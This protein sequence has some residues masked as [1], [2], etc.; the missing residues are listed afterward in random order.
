METKTYPAACTSAYC[1]RTTCPVD[2]PNLET[3]RK[4]KAWRERVAA[5]QPDST[6]SPSVW[7]ATKREA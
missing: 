6:W 7:V 1:G 4:F 2:C 5:V 3:L